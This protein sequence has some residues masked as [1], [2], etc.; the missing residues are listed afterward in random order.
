MPEPEPDLFAKDIEAYVKATFGVE[1]TTAGITAWLQLH[2]FSYKKPAVVPGKANREAQEHWIKDYELLKES[3]PENEAI[4]FIDGVH[5]THN[6]K[7][8]YGW[9]RTGERKEIPT[10]TGRQRINLSGA[11]DIITK[12]VI[13]QQ[14]ITLN[15]NSTIVFLQKLENAYPE[16][17]K[18]HVFC[19]NAKYYKNKD[20]TAYLANSK[21]KM[22][23]LPTYSPNLNP[24]ERL[25]KLMNE[26]VLYNRYY[27]NFKSFKDAVFG[28][29]ES[30]FDP[31][32][33]LA[34]R[35]AKR[36]TDSFSV[37]GKPFS[38][39]KAVATI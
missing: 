33:E 4:C 16:A 6:T 26:E 1:Y 3:L 35:V 9:I 37:I 31:P 28:F 10:N 32:I 5:P 36:V 24:I 25:W 27:E 18:V 2:G 29:L 38:T 7:P 39:E 19:D 8:A 13:V 14:D 17:H 22:H 11:I 21:I 20:V 23:F 34:Q 30:L 12:R 15:A